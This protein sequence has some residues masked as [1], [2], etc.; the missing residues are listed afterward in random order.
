MA[1]VIDTHQA[2]KDLRAAEFSER[3]AKAVAE[4]WRRS[5]E[6][7]LS[8]LVTKTDLELEL[9]RLEN[10]LTTKMGLMTAAGVAVIG[11]MVA[12]F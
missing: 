9:A 1:T 4:L 8:Q 2:V 10:R 11:T 12:I 6:A 3:Q 5:R 7:D